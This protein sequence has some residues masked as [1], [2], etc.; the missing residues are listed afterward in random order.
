MIAFPLTNFWSFI[1]S[2]PTIP[3]LYWDVYSNEQRIKAICETIEKLTQYSNLISEAVNQL[4]DDIQENNAEI[5]A[6]VEAKLKAQQE[7]VDQEI[8]ALKVYIDEAILNISEGQLVYN[9]L[10]GRYQDSKTVNRAL[11][12][13]A[14]EYGIEIQ[15]LNGLASDN[16]L[17]CEGLKNSGLNCLGLAA[18]GY[19]LF[20]SNIFRAM[21]YTKNGLA[22]L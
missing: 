19:A 14:T 1:P 9:P 7:Q 22:P 21:K 3:G 20:D 15:T 16:S 12:Y 8:T 17:T 13:G 4:N 11:F 6:E 5:I 18:I 10:S 2:P